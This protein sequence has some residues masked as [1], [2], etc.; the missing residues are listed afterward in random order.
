V[1]DPAGG[2]ERP[3][4][5]ELGHRRR[6]CP[7]RPVE[8]GHQPVGV[9]HPE[10]GALAEQPRHRRLAGGDAPGEPDP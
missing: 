3:A 4:A 6:P 10:A 8:L 1:V 2:V 7:A 9:D 5:E